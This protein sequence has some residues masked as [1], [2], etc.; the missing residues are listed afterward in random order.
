M[1]TNLHQCLFFFQGENGKEDANAFLLMDEKLEMKDLILHPEKERDI[2]AT[3]TQVVQQKC[4]GTV[5]D[6]HIL[7]LNYTC[8]IVS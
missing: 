6:I 5:G 4:R 1:S 7:D 2:V 3:L 8:N